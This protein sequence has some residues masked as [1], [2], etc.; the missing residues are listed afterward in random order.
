MDPGLARFK[1]LEGRLV[2]K[3][4]QAW[5]ATTVLDEC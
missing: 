3:Q 4:L 2:L 1:G 5:V